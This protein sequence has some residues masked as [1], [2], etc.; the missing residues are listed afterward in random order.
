MAP[1]ASTDALRAAG[2]EIIAAA[3]G[4]EHERAENGLGKLGEIGVQSVLLEGGPHLAGAFL[5]A[6]E[7]DELRLFVA[8]IAVGGRSARVAFEGEGSESISAAQRALSLTSEP[9]GE[10]LLL[11]ARLKEW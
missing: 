2:A 9:V 3:G 11:R 10:D 4:N 5:D 8:P 6:G 1:R 7:I